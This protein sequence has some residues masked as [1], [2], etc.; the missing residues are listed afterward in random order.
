MATSPIIPVATNSAPDPV[1]SVGDL[2]LSSVNQLLVHLAGTLTNIVQAI[3]NVTPTAFWA[4]QGTNAVAV[5]T[6]YN[7][8]LSILQAKAP[9]LVTSLLTGATAKLTSNQDGTITVAP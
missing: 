4:A 5:L 8:W 2:I 9:Q 1:K 6:A 3:N 7:N